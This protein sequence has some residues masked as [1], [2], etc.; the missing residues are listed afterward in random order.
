MLPRTHRAKAKCTTSS[1]PS[2][3]ISRVIP[4]KLWKKNTEKQWSVRRP[5]GRVN[6]TVEDWNDHC[7]QS[8]CLVV[9]NVPHVERSHWKTRIDSLFPGLKSTWQG[10]S[11]CAEN[12]PGRGTLEGLDVL[13]C[14]IRFR[15][16]LLCCSAKTPNQIQQV[17]FLI[18]VGE[19]ACWPD[20]WTLEAENRKVQAF[21][22]TRRTWIL[23]K[24][25]QV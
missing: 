11:C 19:N 16:T 18:Q 6:K 1:V 17:P 20:F 14:L 13:W 8:P 25:L 12:G 21:S 24:T 4:T 3:Y 15:T 7:S 9:C 10:K 2:N 23:Q 5:G 22:V